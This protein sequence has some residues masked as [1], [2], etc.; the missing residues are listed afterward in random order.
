M[1]EVNEGEH[2]VRWLVQWSLLNVL[3]F[4]WIIHL[5]HL[6]SCQLINQ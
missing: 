6:E 1:F 2:Q 3:V 5:T 4:L